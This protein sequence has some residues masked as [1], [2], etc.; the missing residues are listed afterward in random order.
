MLVDLI[1]K[2]AEVFLAEDESSY[3]DGDGYGHPTETKRI[4]CWLLP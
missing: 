3:G 4:L 1:L 2:G